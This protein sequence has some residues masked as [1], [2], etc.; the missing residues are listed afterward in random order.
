[1]KLRNGIVLAI[2]CLA[3]ACTKAPRNESP[4]ATLQE[5]VTVAFEARNADA[6]KKLLALSTGEAKEFLERLSDADFKRQFVDAGLKFISLKTKD[7]RQDEKGDVS[8]VSEL[9]YKDA[10]PD[11]LTEHTNKKIAYLTKEAGGWKIRATKNMKS[12]IERKEDLVVTP[13]TTGQPTK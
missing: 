9:N 8:L 4:E 6:R 10:R 11:S 3:T 12:F 2:A 13:E 5:Y 7:L 1:M